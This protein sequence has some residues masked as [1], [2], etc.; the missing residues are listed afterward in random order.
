MT[1]EVNL[2][3]E[4]FLCGHA[5]RARSTHVHGSRRGGLRCGDPARFPIAKANKKPTWAPLQHAKFNALRKWLGELRIKAVAIAFAHH[6]A[7]AGGDALGPQLRGG[8]IADHGRAKNDATY[9]KSPGGAA[10]KHAR[11]FMAR[12]SGLV[13]QERGDGPSGDPEHSSQS[14][15]AVE[16]N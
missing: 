9:R 6:D 3:N 10:N 8:D 2:V 13:E 4:H 7:V 15:A 16:R 12:R 5:A 14:E 1:L 11:G